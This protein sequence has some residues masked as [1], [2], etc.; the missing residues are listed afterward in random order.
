M[1]EV[2][3]QLEPNE[4]SDLCAV[5][6]A[7]TL[8]RLNWDRAFVT[9]L[10]EAPVKR[11]IAVLGHARGADADEG[12]TAVQPKG[13]PS[14]KGKIEDAESCAR[15]DGWV[16]VLGSQFGKKQGPLE[17]RR[18]WIARVREDE[19]ARGVDGDRPKVELALLRFG[20]HRAVNDALSG[21]QIDLLALGASARDTYIDATI[22]RGAAKDK[23]WA[24][25]V[26]SS[27]HPINV[28]GA[29][30]RP[31]GR[32]LLGLRYPV[33]ADGHPIL[34]ELEDPAAIFAEP[35][36][37]PACSRVWV[38]H[39]VGIA[40]EPMGV[41]ALHARGT[42]TFDAIVGNL[43]SAGKDAAVLEDHPHAVEATSRHVCFS[44][45]MLA[46]GGDVATELVHDF[47]DQHR[48]EGVALGPGGDAHYVVDRE[49]R[50]AL[51]V[52][53]LD[54]GDGLG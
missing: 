48:V 32:M 42:D 53:Q 21:A 38:L 49:G 13:K 24:G 27:D 36:R 52:L 39:D 47:A 37:V 51:R 9:V 23:R 19:L 7:P 35:D 33:T 16:Y 28:E 50:V 26:R 10:D 20:L 11:A 46:A 45:P 5:F 40:G 31:D 44:L 15:F 4:A 30:F 6:D 18:S 1:K 34:V 41:R 14:P 54:G 12:W 17:P 25:R 8:E 29:E 22:A 3:L 43:D 2:D